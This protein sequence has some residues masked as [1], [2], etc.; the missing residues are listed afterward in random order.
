MTE[1]IIV[2]TDGCCKGNQSKD[3]TKRKG[4]IGV[5]F[6]TNEYNLESICCK[7]D[8]SKYVATNNRAEMTAIIM[9][10]EYIMKHNTIINKIKEN[11]TKFTILIKTDSMFC[12]NVITK[13]M[14]NW[15][16][17]NWKKSDKKTIE[18]QDLTEQIYDLMGNVK[19]HNNFNVE[20]KHIRGHQKMPDPADDSKAEEYLEWFGNYWAD[21]LTN[22]A[23]K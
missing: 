1:T 16:R 11:N 5:F 18:N 14:Y 4:G 23:V 10:I 21:A 20:F 6:D 2:F 8:D 22:E 19:K 12:I 17:N 15:K 9:C 7:L 13:W 3:T